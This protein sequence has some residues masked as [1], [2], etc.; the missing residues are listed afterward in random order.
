MMQKKKTSL[1]FQWLPYNPRDHQS[2]L[3]KLE[4]GVDQFQKKKNQKDIGVH[5]KET[6][7]SEI[8]LI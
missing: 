8:K 6:K 3:Q 5:T 1:P 7:I 4:R 2:P